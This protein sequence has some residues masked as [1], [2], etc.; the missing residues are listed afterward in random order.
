MGEG[1]WG[2][3]EAVLD[4]DDSHVGVLLARSDVQICAMVDVNEERARDL[5]NSLGAAA[6]SSVAKMR[7]AGCTVQLVVCAVPAAAQIETLREI[8]SL[9]ARIVICEKPLGLSSELAR[10]V[11]ALYEAN[12]VLL[13]VNYQRR[14]HAITRQL[15]LDIASETSGALEMVVATYSRGLFNNGVHLI[16]YLSQIAGPGRVT[17]ASRSV[18]VSE[19]VSDDGGWDIGVDFDMELERCR[20]VHVLSLPTSELSVWEVH[21]F[22]ADRV[23]HLTSGGRSMALA[24]AVPSSVLNGAKRLKPARLETS[25][26]LGALTGLY[27]AVLAGPDSVMDLRDSGYAAVRTLELAEQARKLSLGRR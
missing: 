2:G 24:T 11:V 7:D 8:L 10:E 17:R 15:E 22:S 26:G 25:V 12:Q 13:V 27:D 5:A 16:D 23:I 3:S 19:A 18:G 4:E 14:F 9:G 1:S 21:L 6:Y 20:K